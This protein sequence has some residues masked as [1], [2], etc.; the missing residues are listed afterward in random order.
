MS[1]WRL[2]PIQGGEGEAQRRR[3]RKIEGQS[4]EGHGTWRSLKDILKK[5]VFKNIFLLYGTGTKNKALP[6]TSSAWV[7]ALIYKAICEHGKPMGKCKHMLHRREC[8]GAAGMDGG[9]TGRAGD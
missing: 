1:L 5:R 8:S 9:F 7:T 6:C 2:I 3:V 4:F